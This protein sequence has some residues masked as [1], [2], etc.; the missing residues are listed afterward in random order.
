[1]KGRVDIHSIFLHKSLAGSI[2]SFRLDALH[3]SEK[4]TEE[5]AESL[6]TASDQGAYRYGRP[7]VCGLSTGR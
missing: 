2:V 6:G 3:F 5:T 1:M 4:I 7:E